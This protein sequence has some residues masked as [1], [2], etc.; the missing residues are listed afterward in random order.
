MQNS[1]WML[2]KQIHFKKDA[3]LSIIN[4]ISINALIFLLCINKKVFMH[5][6]MILGMLTI[7]TVQQAY[8]IDLDLPPTV[9][10]N[11]LA[12]EKRTLISKFIDYLKSDVYKYQVAF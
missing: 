2:F 8:I 11:Q 6:L 10:Y 5:S 9:R 12:Y 3:F 1:L 7:I 4:I